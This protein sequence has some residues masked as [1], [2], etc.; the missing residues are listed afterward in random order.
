M[1]HP[2]PRGCL[3][4]PRP[5]KQQAIARHSYPTEPAEPPQSSPAAGTHWHSEGKSLLL[6]LKAERAAEEEGRAEGQKA[7]GCAALGSGVRE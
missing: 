7:L 3:L 1:P 4:A 6:G 2:W 5:A